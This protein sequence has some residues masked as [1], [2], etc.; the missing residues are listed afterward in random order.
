MKLQRNSYF[1]VLQVLASNKC[2]IPMWPRLRREQN[3]K[4]PLKIAS[5]RAG[6]DVSC[7]CGSLSSALCVCRNKADLPGG[8]E[9]NIDI[10]SEEEKNSV[11]YE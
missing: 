2:V 11:R 1:F 5:R 3:N 6:E 4:F 8:T 7:R 9:K 10:T